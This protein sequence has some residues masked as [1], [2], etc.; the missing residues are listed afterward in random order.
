MEKN[1]WRRDDSQCSSRVED[2]E[3]PPLVLGD[4]AF[5]LRTS[6]LKPYEDGILTDDKQY[7]IYRNSRNNYGM[8][9]QKMENEVQSS[10]S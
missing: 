6:M 1:C 7:L 3:I 2:V 9:I 8:S 5:P 10:F 4:E